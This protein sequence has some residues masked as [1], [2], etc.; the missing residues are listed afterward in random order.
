MVTCIRVAPRF[1]F[2]SAKR[3]DFYRNLHGL[4]FQKSGELLPPRQDHLESDNTIEVFAGVC[5]LLL[6]F[7]SDLAA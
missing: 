4:P 1:R 7:C 3:N 5:G 2:C 6:L